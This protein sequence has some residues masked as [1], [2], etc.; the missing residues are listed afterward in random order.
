MKGRRAFY[1][2]DG[3]DDVS[4]TEFDLWDDVPP[5]NEASRTMQEILL[6][7][8][9]EDAKALARKIVRDQ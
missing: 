3:K 6:S 4:E 8:T 9:P 7:R 5:V 2:G 1:V